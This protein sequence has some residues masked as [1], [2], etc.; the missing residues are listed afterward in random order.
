[1]ILVVFESKIYQ[2]LAK[3]EASRYA[4]DLDIRFTCWNQ[5]EQKEKNIDTLKYICTLSNQRK[6]SCSFLKYTKL[7]VIIIPEDEEPG[8]SIFTDIFTDMLKL[9]AYHIKIY[10]WRSRYRALRLH[11][12]TLARSWHP[13]P[14][15]MTWCLVGTLLFYIQDVRRYY[16]SNND[17]WFATGDR[18]L[19][20]DLLNLFLAFHDQQGF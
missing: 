11:R 15:M 20:V 3:M 13:S 4:E 6:V 19:V 7:F 10:L 2:F 9:Q 5:W 17:A 18:S 12:L 16:A 8:I 14:G 1:M